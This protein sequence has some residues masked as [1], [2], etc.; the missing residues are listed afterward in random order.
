MRVLNYSNFI[1]KSGKLEEKSSSLSFYGDLN[2]EKTLKYPVEIKGGKTIPNESA[3]LMG[4]NKWDVITDYVQKGDT[5]KIWGGNYKNKA[6]KL[7]DYQPWDDKYLDG[8]KKVSIKKSEDPTVYKAAVKIV[9]ALIKITKPQGTPFANAADVTSTYSLLISR[10]IQALSMLRSVM[11]IGNTEREELLKRRADA[12]ERESDVMYSLPDVVN[13]RIESFKIGEKVSDALGMAIENPTAQGNEK[14]W[15]ELVSIGDQA[16]EIIKL[17]LASLLKKEDPKKGGEDWYGEVLKRAR[18]EVVKYNEAFASGGNGASEFILNALKIYQRGAVKTLNDV[19]KGTSL[20]DFQ[21][22]S[23]NLP[24]V[25]DQVKKPLRTINESNIYGIKKYSTLSGREINILKNPSHRIFEKKK[26]GD[27]SQVQEASY[28]GAI[29]TMINLYNILDATVA[30]FEN[31]EYYDTVKNS[32]NPLKSKIKKAYDFLTSDNFDNIRNNYP[33]QLEKQINEI[34]E[35]NDPG[36]TESVPSWQKEM[37]SKYENAVVSDQYIQ[38]GDAELA[39]A[40]DILNKMNKVTYLKDKEAQN[41]LDNIVGRI[42]RS[43]GNTPEEKM[44]FQQKETADKKAR[45][46][47]L[48]RSLS[49]FSSGAG[50]EDLSDRDIED[51]IK[52]ASLLTG[53][54]YKD[55]TGAINYQEAANDIEAIR[56]KAFADVIR[57]STGQD[58]TPGSG[59]ETQEE[60]TEG[61]SVKGNNQDQS[62]EEEEG[63]EKATTTKAIEM[64]KKASQILQELIDNA[65]DSPQPLANVMGAAKAAKKNEWS[66]SKKDLDATLDDDLCSPANR[67]KVESSLKSA[68]K[69]MDDNGKHLSAREKKQCQELIDMLKEFPKYCEM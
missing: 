40:T 17:Y 16:Q 68:Q 15:N 37:F 46:E 6:A 34:I 49:A 5:I 50:G 14:M 63:V 35:L 47:E 23:K 25:Q 24:G 10:A 57:K 42:E 4:I 66:A 51:I 8:V 39:K 53:K 36:N 12:K 7:S 60:R 27:L 41:D 26:R 30:Y 31:S 56:G 33:D 43:A 45:E 52:S 20:V 3:F 11:P 64:K 59:G 65:E 69:N 55:S 32:A 18:T 1:N 61:S 38:A 19:K 62:Q 22:I 21:T 28:E 9:D 48:K 54:T 67:A 2:E 58:V 13:S 44:T 29:S